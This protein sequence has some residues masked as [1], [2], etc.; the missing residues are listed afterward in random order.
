MRNMKKIE[1]SKN[2]AKLF[3]VNKRINDMDS[4]AQKIMITAFYHQSREKIIEDVKAYYRHLE[5]TL[6]KNKEAI[7]ARRAL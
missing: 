4:K 1:V 6:D 2:Q 3:R 7:N 5:S